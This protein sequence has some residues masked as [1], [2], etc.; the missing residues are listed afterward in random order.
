[1]LISSGLPVGRVRHYRLAQAI[2]AHK[3]VALDLGVILA[4]LSLISESRI[5]SSN[6][7]VGDAARIQTRLQP[8]ERIH[9][10]SL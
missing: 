6:L 10:V 4:N 9:N 1:L 8:A 7:S 2:D 3:S 5:V